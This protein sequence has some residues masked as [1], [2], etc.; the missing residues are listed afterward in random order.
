MIFNFYLSVAACGSVPAVI[1]DLLPGGVIPVT[2]ILVLQWLPC[3]V[4]GS[5]GSALG[6]AGP[7]SVHCDWVR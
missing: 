3:L 4:P 1:V 2:K 7:V 5:V 6:L